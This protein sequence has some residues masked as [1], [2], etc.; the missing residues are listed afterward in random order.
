MLTSPLIQRVFLHDSRIANILR[1]G[2]ASLLLGMF[3]CTTVE[4]MS[5]V[6]CPHRPVLTPITVEQQ[7]AMDSQVLEIVLVNQSNLKRYAL[8]LEERGYDWI[9]EKHSQKVAT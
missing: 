4:V 6:P 2:M 8:K 9:R 3:G 5:D 1:L 7:L